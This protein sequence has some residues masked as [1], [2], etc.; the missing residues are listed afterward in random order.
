MRFKDRGTEDLFHG[1]STK[2]ARAVLPAVLENVF[3]RKLDQLNTVT[4]LDQL[5]IPPSN[6]LEALKGNRAGQFSIR[7]NERYRVCF[8]WIANEPTDVE[9][10]DYH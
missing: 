3:R 7:I 10:A 6:R 2:A 8:R 4:R 1:R 5:R 9:I